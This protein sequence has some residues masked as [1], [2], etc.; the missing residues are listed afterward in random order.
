VRVLA[1]WSALGVV[2]IAPLCASAEDWPKWRGPRGDNIS[3]EEGLLDALPAQGLKEKWKVDIGRSYSSPV[4]AGGKLFAM[5]VS[6]GGDDTLFCL[7][8]DSGKVHWQKSYKGGWSEIRKYAGVRATPMV[9]GDKVYTYGGKGD[10]TSWNVADGAKNWQV[11]VL[12]ETGA[13]THEWG[14]ASNPLLVGDILYVQSGVGPGVPVLV[15]V[16]AKS[17]KIVKKSEAVGGP[18]PGGDEGKER[19]AQGGGYAHPI[20][21]E[22]GGKQLLLTFASD[23]IHAIDPEP[24]KTAWSHKHVTKY[25]VNASTPVYHDGHLF[26]TSAYGTGSAMLKVTA[27]G[28]EQVWADKSIQSRFQGAI[29]DGGHLYLN[30]EGTVMCLS[31]PDC[32]TKWKEN[33]RLAAGGSLIRYG[34]DKLL[35]L[36]ERGKLSLLRATPEKAEKLGEWQA[37]DARE[38]WSTPL[39]WQKKLYLKGTTELVCYEFGK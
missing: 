19:F 12:K 37:L 32:K 39:L 2:C 11:N 8:P 18:K 20:L 13:S 3:K 29:L 4:V 6:A 21:A 28:A 17:G 15:G 34:G 10:L 14:E 5:A 26:I 36:S 38:A 1:K 33:L 31:W 24:M 7:D 30:S 9:V 16:D 27:T 25:D 22:V 23:S 35:A